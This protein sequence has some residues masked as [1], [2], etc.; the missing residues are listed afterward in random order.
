MSRVAP[1]PDRLL[2]A[3]RRGNEARLAAIYLTRRLTDEAVGKIGHNFGDVSTA[4]ISKAVHRA[5]ARRKGD[6]RWDR[7]LK[8][9]TANL[10]IPPSAGAT[11]SGKFQVK[12]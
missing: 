1:H 10:S 11:T 3:R 7:Q 8:K 9:L 6:R 2:L 12:T 5:E 4:A